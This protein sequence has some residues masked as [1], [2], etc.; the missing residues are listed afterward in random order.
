MG[1]RWYYLFIF[2]SRYRHAL[3]FTKPLTPNKYYTLRWVSGIQYLHVSPLDSITIELGTQ[4]LSPSKQLKRYLPLDT[5]NARR[6]YA[7][8]FVADSSYPYL[9]L[10]QNVYAFG[11]GRGMIDDVRLDTCV[12]LL[13]ARTI[14][15]AN[16]PMS[17]QAAFTGKQVLWNT[18]DTL[19]AITVNQNGTY[20]AQIYDSFGCVWVDSVTVVATPVTA[21][22]SFTSKQI[23]IGDSVVLQ[24]KYNGTYMWNTG[25]TT[26]NIT[27]KDS[28]VYWVYTTTSGGCDATDT[29]KVVTQ[30][31]PTLN[32]VKDTSFCNGNSIVINAYNPYYT[33][34]KW[35]T[36][37]TDSAIT[38][39][40]SGSYKV[41]A[42]NGICTLNDSILV[43]RIDLSANRLDTSLCSGDTIVLTSGL[44]NQ[45]N[46]STGAITAA[47][48]V[49]TP[50]TYWVIKTQNNCTASDS[51]IVK[52]INKPTSTTTDTFYCA[53]Q[54][55]ELFATQAQAYLWNNNAQ[56]QAITINVP[57][58]YTVQKN[59]QHCTGIDS[60]F[61]T[62]KPLPVI[63]SLKDT[64]VCFD[65]VAQILLDAGQFK[66]YLWK[67]TGETTQTIYSNT[68]QVYLLTV[69][70]SNNCSTS[71]QVAVMETCPEFVYVP[72]AFTPNGD[73]LNDVFL[74]KTRAIENYEL[75]IINRWGA[76]IFT[77]QNPQQ[78][79]DGKDAPADVYI[80]QVRYNT[81]GKATKLIKQNISLLR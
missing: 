39:N 45:Y 36:N 75:T 72:T 70:D 58:L 56:T 59:N 25:D 32:L 19:L 30:I 9:F 5:G 65:E 66:S 24:S 74:P 71:K 13:P 77:T 3:N 33:H 38:I 49:S 20:I 54:F 1:S 14:G 60:F 2:F 47:I 64:T 8:T 52:N 48:S 21:P 26:Q 12:T 10:S 28:G 62:E 73:G 4:L 27:V 17:I 46:W 44:A 69:T 16:F 53:T 35:S 6:T 81:A 61:V 11:S 68:A 43:Q 31:P 22:S 7:V 42:T 23:C 51:F 63:L 29:F 37:S 55:V 40:Q 41:T 34:Y 80:A 67:P 18:G 76:I 15:C 57:V 78:G 50:A 79:W